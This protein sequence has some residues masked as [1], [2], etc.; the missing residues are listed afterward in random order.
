MYFTFARPDLFGPMRTFGRG[1]AVAPGNHLTEQRA[2][3]LVKTS[4]E[5][6]LTA[7]SRKELKWYLA[8]VEVEGTHALALISAFFDDPDNPLAI[9]TPLVPSDSLCSTLADLPDEFDVCF[10]DE[11]N[12]E[13]LSCRASASLAYLR[14]KIRDLPALCDPDAH[15]MI[16]QAELWFSL[17]TDLND[18]EAF[19]V[20][21]GEELF[22]SDFVYFDLREDRHAFHGSS[23]FSTNT[24]VRPEPGPYQE[25]DIVFLLQRVF[26]AKEIIH[27]PIKPSD[28]EELVDVAVLGGEVNLFLQAKDS[29][30]TEAMINRSLDRKRRVSLNQLVGGLSQ[31]GGAFSTALR[32]PVQ[33]LRLST[34]ASIQVDF[35]DKPMLGIV[36]VKELFTD[37]YDAYSE[38]ALAFMDKHQIPVVFFDYSELEVL[39]RRCETEAAFLSA[40]HAVFR[41]A[42]ENGEYPKLRF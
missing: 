28:N 39:T 16:D 20:L 32:A 21:L 8:P 40:C 1:I 24:L 30:N 6:I 17:R 12:R 22:P 38:R 4:K 33:Q 14:A 7:R 31:L 9:T 11:H 13:Q 5:I 29:P 3:L 23:G 19:P 2:V 41:F 34:G 15:M 26:S 18:R 36:I 42:V 25:R 35:S 37:M 27:G 10:L